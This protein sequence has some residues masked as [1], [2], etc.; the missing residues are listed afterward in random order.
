M[1]LLLDRNQVLDVYAESAKKA[2]VLPTFNS[3]NLTTTEAILAATKNYGEKIG[4]NDL[5]III[6]ITNNYQFRPQSVFYTHTRRW[7]IGMKLFLKDIEILTS[8]N[9]PYS[10]LKVMIHLDHIQWDDDLEL[11]DWDMGQFSSI[12]YDA[13]TLP[14]EKNIELTTQFRKKH[15]QNILIEGGCDVIGKTSEEDGGLT[16]PEDAYRYLLETGVDIIVA[17]LGTEHRASSAA[18]KY[19]GDLAREI[20]RKFGKGCLCLHGTSSVSLDS[21]GELFN[22]GIRKVNIWTA[23]ERDSSKLLLQEMVKNA[24]K[25]VDQKQISLMIE[26]KIFGKTVMKNNSV[27]VEYYTTTYRQNIVYL[28]MQKLVTNYLKIFYKV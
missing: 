9:S 10:N 16:S 17:N 13:S 3:E 8:Q 26:K 24:S 23:L 4:I 20:S 7:D 27:S 15:N 6:G 1:P 22:D 11:L 18:L 28:E 5:P 2:W 25:I 12:M 21:L 19:R 14:F